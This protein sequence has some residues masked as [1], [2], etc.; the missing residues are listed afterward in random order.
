MKLIEAIVKPFKLDE[1]KD[2]LLEIGIQGMTVTEVKGFGRQKGHKETYRG[3]EYTIEFVPKVKIE[4]AVNDGQVQRVL[5]TIT[6]AA[7]TGSIGDGKIFVR[8]LTSAVRIRTGE[9]GES[10]L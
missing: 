1:V 6:R 5:E 2:A 10:A 8:D 9:T 4:V 3:Q 7:K